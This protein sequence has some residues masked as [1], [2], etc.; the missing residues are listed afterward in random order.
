M[1]KPIKIVVVVVVIV[2]F[3]NKKLQK[4]FDPTLLAKKFF[5]HGLFLDHKFLD[6]HFLFDKTTTTTTTITSLMGFDTIENNLVL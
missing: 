2:V 6:L 1:S 5:G 4:Y 3:V